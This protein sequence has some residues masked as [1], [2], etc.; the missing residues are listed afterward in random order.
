MPFV[1]NG[2][3]VSWMPFHGEDPADSGFGADRFDTGDVTG[4]SGY[5]DPNSVSLRNLALIALGQEPTPR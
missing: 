1:G 4:H 5:F 2:D 3:P